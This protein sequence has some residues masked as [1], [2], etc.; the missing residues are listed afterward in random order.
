MSAFGPQLKQGRRLRRSKRLG[1]AVGV[2][3]HGQDASRERF[4]EFTQMLSVNAYGGLIALAAPVEK[5]QRT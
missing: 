3:V 1:L 2:C 4:R 5:G